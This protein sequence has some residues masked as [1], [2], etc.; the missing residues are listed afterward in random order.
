MAYILEQRAT[1]SPQYNRTRRGG[2]RPSGT[3]VI[4]TAENRTDKTGPDSGAEAVLNWIR[5]R[6]DPGSYHSLIDADS[7]LRLIDP[8]SEA[9]HCK[10]TNKWS[11]GLSCAVSASDWHSLYQIRERGSDRGHIIIDRLAAEAAHIIRWIRSTYGIVVPVRRISRRDAL[12]RRPGF[13]A[14]GETDPGRRTDPGAAFDWTYFLARV[15]VHLNPP[16][17]KD[18]FLMALTAA[19]QANLLD[20][21]IK[22]NHAA[23]RLDKAVPQLSARIEA[24]DA[25]IDALTALVTKAMEH[26]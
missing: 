3:I 25:K 8:A 5:S 23:G 17:K 20:K 9:F 18:E 21:T 16:T 2:Y 19:D 4:H 1:A 26:E 15:S 10:Y 24:L 7:T 6:P 13:I 14:H 12:A 11:I 22:T